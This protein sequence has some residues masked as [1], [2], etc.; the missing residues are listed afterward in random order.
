V[1][2]YDD[3]IGKGCMDNGGR[4]GGGGK[5][6]SKLN[7]ISIIITFSTLPNFPCSLPDF[8]QKLCLSRLPFGLPMALPSLLLS[9]RTLCKQSKI[10]CMQDLRN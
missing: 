6:W 1:G 2:G 10:V 7:L 3:V 9:L 4:L 5:G 8:F